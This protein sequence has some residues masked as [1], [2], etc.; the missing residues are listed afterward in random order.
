MQYKLTLPVLVAIPQLLV[1]TTM[2][3]TESTK[4]SSDINK[5]I[6]DLMDEGIEDPIDQAGVLAQVKAESN[7]TPRSENLNYSA[8]RLL[9]VFPRYFR[10]IEDAE[11]VVNQGPQ[12]IGNRIYGGRM[13]N[14]A[15]EGYTYRG[16]GYIQLTGKDNYERYGA[17]IGEDLVAD[18]D[19]AND[20]D[21]ARKLAIAYLKENAS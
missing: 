8:E 14:A 6:T 1:A 5:W 21:V 7:F 13:G 20:P 9:A 10:N 2:P 12:A 19:K 15:D 18:P 16:R 3:L 4:M 17:L 11:A